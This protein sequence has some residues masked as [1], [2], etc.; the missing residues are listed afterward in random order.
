MET[1]QLNRRLTHHYVGTYAHEDNWAG[2]GTARLTPPR[3]VVEGNGLDDGGTY[4]R[5]ATLPAGQD[6][7]ASAQAL[8]DTL[9]KHGCHHEYDCCGCRSVSTRVIHRHG[10]RL[11]LRIRV[12]FNY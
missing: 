4:I 10:R 3:E 2:V 5:W 8:E 9:S 6:V 7:E 11:V 1:I 12:S